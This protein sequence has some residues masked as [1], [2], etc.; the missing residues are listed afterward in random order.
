MKKQLILALWLTAAAVEASQVEVPLKDWTVPKS[1][2]MASSA[3]S[4]GSQ[5]I[6]VSPCRVQDT[7]VIAGGAAPI[8]AGGTLTVV[9]AGKCGVPL[10]ATAFSLNF[11]VTDSPVSAS[12]GFISAY[13]TGQ[14]W[15]GT[16]TVNFK[17]GAQIANAAIVPAGTNGSIDI[18]AFIQTHVIVDVNGYFASASGTN[19][20]P[21]SGSTGIGTAAPAATLQVAGDVRIG[22]NGTNTDIRIFTDTP[23]SL[24]GTAYTQVTSITPVTVPPSGT[25]RSA[26][27]LKNA[28]A[29]GQGTN[30]LDLVVDGNI[31]A[32]Y[33]DLAEMV[34]SRE[35][36]TPGTVVVLDATN[37]KHVTTSTREY[38]TAVAG[39]IS[40]QPGIT[41][42][43]P[44]EGSVKV[45]TT[46]RV[47]VRAD[48]TYGAIRVGDLLVTSPTA[49]TAMRS[50]PVEA[51]GVLLHRPGT[52]IGKAIEPLATGRGEIL[53][54]LSLQ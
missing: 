27:Y 45:A 22:S 26:L 8:P 30:Q 46:G 50:K 37:L 14:P 43:L 11:T 6:A 18:Y 40:S 47:K 5:F 36:L 7:R 28:T 49:G 44:S 39:V 29:N 54:L 34:P 20:F 10:G 24:G 33:Q 15:P 42:G 3:V 12:T 38:D 23:Q 9:V 21:A 31:A 19:V 1:R 35:E 13:P 32:K 17:G 51:G 48:A 25:T 4:N 52:I 41:L 16:S 2:V 53:V